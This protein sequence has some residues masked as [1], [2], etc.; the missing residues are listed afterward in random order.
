MIHSCDSSKPV[1]KVD[2][3]KVGLR[4]SGWEGG[5]LSGGRGGGELK[6]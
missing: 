2:G 6:L 5:G 3:G 1:E 4:G